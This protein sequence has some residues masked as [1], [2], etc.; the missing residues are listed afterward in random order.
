MEPVLRVSNTFEQ[1]LTESLIETN[2]SIF[3]SSDHRSPKSLCKRGQ[4]GKPT[5][6]ALTLGTPLSQALENLRN[7]DLGFMF[8]RI[9]IVDSMVGCKL[10]WNLVTLT[11]PIP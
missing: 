7:H 2:M 11:N 8:V 3:C 10:I 9:A 6:A 1:N 4:P 5:L